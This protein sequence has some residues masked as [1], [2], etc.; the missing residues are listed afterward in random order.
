MTNDPFK[1]RRD[2][3]TRIMN[4]Y[5]VNTARYA[6]EIY[7]LQKRV[8]GRN[9]DVSRYMEALQAA[10]ERERVLYMKLAK[11]HEVAQRLSSLA[12][13]HTL[14]REDHRVNLSICLYNLASQ[15]QNL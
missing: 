4:E 3:I 12:N 7:E 5:G 11:A 1:E 8:E 6:E 15:L 9:E 14:L 2:A 13:N 10:D